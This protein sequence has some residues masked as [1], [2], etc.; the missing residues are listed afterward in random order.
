MINKVFGIGLSRTGTTS[1]NT[2]LCAL[3]IKS[4]HFPNDVQTY[5]ELMEARYNLTV[6]KTYQGITDTPVVPIYPQLDKIY[7]GSKFILTIRDKESWLNSVQ[8]HWEMS[9]W[10]RGNPGLYTVTEYGYWAFNRISVYGCVVFDRDR[11]SCVYDMH[12][13]NVRQYFTDRRQDLL[14]LNICGG[15]GWGPLCKFLD[16]PVPSVSFPYDNGRA[17]MTDFLTR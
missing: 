13:R 1:L 5:H 8:R 10:V 17:E 15:D 3:G 7:P 4:I 9:G 6:L 16:K 11:F 12:N 2:A 14:V